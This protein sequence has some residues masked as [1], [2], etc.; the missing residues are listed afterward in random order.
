M[1]LIKRFNG[2]KDKLK[3]FIIYIKI[4]IINKGLGLPILLD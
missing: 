4:K 3:G 1:L 2:N